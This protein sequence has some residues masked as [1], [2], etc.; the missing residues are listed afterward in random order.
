[1]TSALLQ[2]LL[3]STA[4]L[5]VLLLAGMF[6]RAKVPLFR[7]FLVPASVIGGFLGLLL[8]PEILG[9]T[10]VQ[11]ISEDWSATW[12]LLASILVVPMFAGTPLGNFR[13][14]GKKR[15][16][17]RKEI[18][19]ISIIS[20]IAS[21]AFGFQIVLGVGIPLLLLRFIPGLDFYNNFGYEICQG[22]N[23]GHSMAGAI[24]NIL[25]EGGVAHWELAQGVVTTFATIG[26]LGGILIGV[27]IINRAS[28][29]GKTAILK[30]AAAL[31]EQSTYGFTKNIEEQS[32]LGR[33]T[34]TSSSIETLTVH[35]GVILMDCGLAYWLHGL[36]VKYHVIG[37]QDIPVWPYALI[38]MYGVNYIIDRLGLQWMIDARV[39]THICGVLA[40]LSITAAIASM[41]IRAVLVYMLPI[42]LISAL[43]FVLVYFTTIKMFEVLLPDTYPFERGIL[44]WGIN[45]GVM[46][47]GVTLLKICDPNMETPV[48]SDYSLSYAIR[49]VIE[50]IT[51]PI[52]YGLLVRGTSMQMLWFGVLY[53][54]G[55]Y[56]IVLLGKMMYGKA[57][58]PKE[59]VSAGIEETA[60]V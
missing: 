5:C 9:Q 49:Q 32:E 2:G 31:P 20:G 10:G 21:G 41:P 34:T 8:G 50:L 42:V 33:E 7:R 53:V 52:M 18:G 47:T 22:F 14:P 25:M 28:A 26:L 3:K 36:A 19:K 54:L 13:D 51:T 60:A 6:L 30:S 57:K 29:K 23:G 1:M 39:K 16:S 4:G 45:T 48:M 56:L 12:S 55:C 38:L 17:G 40:D 27:F 11:V 43:G 24:G 46:M 58:A 37:L 35:L 59:G 15:L 44:S